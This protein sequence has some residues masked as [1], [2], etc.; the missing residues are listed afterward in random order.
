MPVSKENNEVNP[1]GAPGCTLGRQ[2]PKCTGQVPVSVGDYFLGTVTLQSVMGQWLNRRL[3]AE[4]DAKIWPSLGR[5]GPLVRTSWG[6]HSLQ[7]SGRE[8]S[9]SQGPEA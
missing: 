5:A 8:T 6:L 9:R 2:A 4:P 3:A 1:A 7:D